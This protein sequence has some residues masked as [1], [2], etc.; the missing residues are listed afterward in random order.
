VRDESGAILV[1]Y[2][3]SDF[4]DLRL[5]RSTDGGRTRSEPTPVPPTEKLS[6]Y[7]AR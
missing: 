1:V 6:I 5:T 4:K 3:K 2:S 7:P